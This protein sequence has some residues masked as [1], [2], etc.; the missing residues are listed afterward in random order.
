MGLGL[1]MRNH[2][3]AKRAKYFSKYCSVTEQVLYNIF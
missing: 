2:N 1:K 3:I